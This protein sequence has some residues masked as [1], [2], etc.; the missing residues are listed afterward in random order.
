MKDLYSSMNQNSEHINQ[1]NKTTTQQQ[2]NSKTLEQQ[3]S[4]SWTPVGPTKDRSSGPSQLNW[5]LYAGTIIK[6]EAHRRAI[7]EICKVVNRDWINH[8]AWS[9]SR[10]MLYPILL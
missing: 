7:K 1:E 10:C 5:K 4:N 2:T 3:K 6:S 8:Q 9:L